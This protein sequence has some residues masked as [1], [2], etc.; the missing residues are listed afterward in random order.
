MG[1]TIGKSALLSA[2]AGAAGTAMIR[3]MMKASQQFAPETLPP[4]KEDPGHFM[5]KQAKR[6]LPSNVEISEK[7]EELAAG[8]LAFGY[9]MTLAGVYGAARPRAGNTWLEG[10]GL[11]LATWAVGYLGWLPATKLAPPVWKHETKQ[12][13]PGILSHVLFGIATVALFK[14]AKDKLD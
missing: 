5:V 2:A 7:T 12:V 13:V 9:G 3:G 8:A 1:T 6:V 11:G 14:W 10:T 4:I